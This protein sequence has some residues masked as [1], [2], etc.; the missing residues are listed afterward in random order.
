M[1]A[2]RS[3][4][5]VAVRKRAKAAQLRE[6]ADTLE[7]DADHW[8]LGDLG[9]RVVGG[10][11]ELLRAEGWYVVHDVRWPGRPRANLDHVVVGPPGVLVVDAKNWSGSV[12][13]EGGR[14]R[15]NGHPR[16]REVQAVADAADAVRTRL[17]TAVAVLPVLCLA[18]GVGRTAQSSGRTTVLSADELVGWARALPAH[19]TTDDVLRLAAQV[20]QELPPAGASH[21]S[22]TRAGRHTRVTSTRRAATGARRR[23]VHVRGRTSGRQLVV[24]LAVA[25]AALLVLPWSLS[26]LAGSLAAGAQPGPTAAAAAPTVTAPVV[27]PGC[28]ALRATYPDGAKA[29]GATNAGRRARPVTVVDTALVTANAPLDDDGDGLVCERPRTRHRSAKG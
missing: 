15:Q 7:R 27:F 14:L 11:L 23:L 28:R 1:T 25:A 19:L 22:T 18:S 5:Q 17:G 24:R 10:R 3:A 4:Q 16:D 26:Q 2:G 9:E 6:Q 12:T 20:R 8:E 29:K 21:P 13:L